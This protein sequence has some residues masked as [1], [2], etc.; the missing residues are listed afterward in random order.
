MVTAPGIVKD[1]IGA[2][3]SVSDLI[4]AYEADGYSHN[5]MA[6]GGGAVRCTTCGLIG[7]ASAGHIQAF[8]RFEGASDPDDMSM[9]IEVLRTTPGGARCAGVLVVAFG[10]TAS[11]ED[12]EAFAALQ[13]DRPAD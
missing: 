11:P 13:F 9:V 12:R 2:E 6:L 1:E 4:L 3:G 7:P 10:P 8:R 5:L